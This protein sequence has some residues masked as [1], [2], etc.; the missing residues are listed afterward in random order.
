MTT[1]K[2]LSATAALWALAAGCGNP[3]EPQSKDFLGVMAIQ[4]EPKPNGK[5]GDAGMHGQGKKKPPPPEESSEEAVKARI[6]D[7]KKRD[8]L[9]NKR[10]PEEELE[11]LIGESN[12]KPP[13]NHFERQLLMANA[14]RLMRKLPKASHARV[15]QRVGAILGDPQWITE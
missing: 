2:F 5:S 4:D 15:V 9:L 1:K 10:E 13:E 6:A 12:R 8:A 3:Q 7:A 11:D 14:A